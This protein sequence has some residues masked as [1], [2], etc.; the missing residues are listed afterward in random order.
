MKIEVKMIFGRDDISELLKAEYQKK[1][2]IP[3]GYE[4][5]ASDSHYGEWH[6]ELVEQDK[7]DIEQTKEVTTDG[8]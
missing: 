8:N 1:F 6:V 2:V 4:L 7:P 3:A 5:L